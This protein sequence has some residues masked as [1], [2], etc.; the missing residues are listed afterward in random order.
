MLIIRSMAA[1]VSSIPG[2]GGTLMSI[3]S[4]KKAGLHRRIHFSTT[5]SNLPRNVCLMGKYGIVGWIVIV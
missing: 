4:I 2:S 1:K 3:C 5:L